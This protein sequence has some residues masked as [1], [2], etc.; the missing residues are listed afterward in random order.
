M[1]PIIQTANSA[2][3]DLIAQAD[4]DLY[5]GGRVIV[6][7]GYIYDL[8]RAS[9]IMSRSGLAFKEGIVA[10]EGLID[11]DY[12]QEVKVLL[13]NLNP[14]GYH[15]IPYKIKVGDRIAQIVVLEV[16]TQEFFSVTDKERDGGIGSTGRSGVEL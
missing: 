11:A 15:K 4:Y 7:T 13:F 8:P 10:F 2:G 5:P 16:C 14:C 12:R 1:R 6:S 3:A 9:K